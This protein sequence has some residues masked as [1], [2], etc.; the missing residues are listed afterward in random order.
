M[1]ETARDQ[2]YSLFRSR[3]QAIWSTA[4]VVLT[5]QG[6][7]SEEQQ[8]AAWAVLKASGLDGVASLRAE[9]AGGLAGWRHRLLRRSIRSLRCCE[10]RDSCGRPSPM[11]PCL[12][13]GGR[14]VRAPRLLRRSPCR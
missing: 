4:A 5:I 2:L 8:A 10:A 11:R 1:T 7:A 6:A 9:E 12:R 13:R 3:D 14:A